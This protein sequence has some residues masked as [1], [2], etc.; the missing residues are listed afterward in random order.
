MNKK[1]KITKAEEAEVHRLEDLSV[2][3]VSVVDRPANQRP[4]L[5]VKA[6][7]VITDEDGNLVTR[8]A[9][10]VEEV[11]REEET[12]QVSTDVDERLQKFRNRVEEVNKAFELSL[13]EKLYDFADSVFKARGLIEKMVEAFMLADLGAEKSD[14]NFVKSLISQIEASRSSLD[15][16]ASYLSNTEKAEGEEEVKEETSDLDFS[17]LVSELETSVHK[18]GAKIS[19]SRLNRLRAIQAELSTLL[20]EVTPTEEVEEASVEKA[21]KKVAK[22]QK[23]S[24]PTDLYD[25][26]NTN[27]EKSVQWP[28]DMSR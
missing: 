12:E 9:A 22:V 19:A 1:T 27:N 16:V 21:A 3:E 13:G 18:A 5:L 25:S 6:E 7:D 14:P 17:D 28:S 4:F 20:A 10:P 2:Y 11:D 15:E 8:K 23:S 24:L 26:G